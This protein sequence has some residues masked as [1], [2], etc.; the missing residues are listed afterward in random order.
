MIAAIP[1]LASPIVA[2][3]VGYN[4][5]NESV[6]LSY[7]DLV[8]TGPRSL[9]ARSKTVVNLP[10][11]Y[12]NGSEYNPVSFSGD[13]KLACVGAIG[14]K[15]TALVIVDNLRRRIVRIAPSPT[16][17]ITKFTPDNRAV[18][19]IRGT[20]DG[21]DLSLVHI[22]S[23]DRMDWTH[24]QGCLPAS[25]T[26]SVLV[27]R[28]T[29]WIC[30]WDRGWHR[31]SR[32]PADFLRA[33]PILRRIATRGFAS[34]DN[35]SASGVRTPEAFLMRGVSKRSARPVRRDFWPLPST[36]PFLRDRLVTFGVD[37][38]S[39]EYFREQNSQ[40][41]DVWRGGSRLVRMNGGPLYYRFDAEA[42]QHRSSLL[43]A[44]QIGKQP[45][46]TQCDAVFGAEPGIA[47]MRD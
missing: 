39:P 12:R 25:R 44:I 26:P 3:V 28:G 10:P 37:A 18:L 27:S 31:D 45:R 16:V 33:D 17:E 15:G 8:R 34:L 11:G 6:R 35:D 42:N 1:S 5:V 20:R 24:V 7:T 40:P 4:V 30:R 29:F 41:Y 22:A 21:S 23:G 43:Y 14:P 9:S 36:G 46:I 13:G 2:T 47:L 19:A 32:R 38:L